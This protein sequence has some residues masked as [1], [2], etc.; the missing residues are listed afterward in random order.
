MSKHQ[1]FSYFNHQAKLLRFKPPRLQDTNTQ[2]K[3]Q[4]PPQLQTRKTNA[5]NRYL[6]GRGW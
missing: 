1:E 2:Q 3:P 4:A 5:Y 6:S